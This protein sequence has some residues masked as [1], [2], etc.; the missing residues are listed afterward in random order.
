MWITTVTVQIVR[1]W[2]DVRLNFFIVI[3]QK[4][5]QQMLYIFDFKDSE[6]TKSCYIKVLLCHINW[7][8]HLIC[9]V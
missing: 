3:V 6:Y 5:K 2:I 4:K 8:N 9:L 7:L 1:L